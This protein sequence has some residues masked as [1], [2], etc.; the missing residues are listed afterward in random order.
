MP[1]VNFDV[2]CDN[3]SGPELVLIHNDPQKAD[4]VTNNKSRKRTTRPSPAM[5]SPLQQHVPHARRRCNTGK[6]NERAM[7]R[8]RSRGIKLEWSRQ[9]GVNETDLLTETGM[10]LY[11]GDFV[12]NG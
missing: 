2:D 4:D 1:L 7:T 11:I 8:A 12:D 9:L 10:F 5:T 6:K 3:G